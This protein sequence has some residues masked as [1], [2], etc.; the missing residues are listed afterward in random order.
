M[1]RIH[2]TILLLSATV[3]TATAAPRFAIIR[4]KD[5]Y[6]ALPSTADLQEEIKN[7]RDEIMKDE[8]ADLL[9]KIISELQTIQA[10]LSDRNNPLDEVTNRKLARHYEI[11]RQEA[12]TLQQKFENFKSEKEKLINRK[13]VAG[14]RR[15]LNRIT[16]ASQKLAKEK[17]FDAVFDGSGHTNTGVPFV[18]YS[19][20]APDLTADVQALLKDIEPAEKPVEKA[21]AKP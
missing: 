16:A 14:M 4:V 21:P 8:H 3:V 2:F 5:I 13:M 7:E 9:R 6:T 20:A 15:S 17:G 12:Q 1:N 19:K 11:K 18:L 10:Q